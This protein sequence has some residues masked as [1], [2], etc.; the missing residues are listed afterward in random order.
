MWRHGGFAYVANESSSK[1]DV[2]SHLS[3]LS[4]ST[5]GGW[6]LWLLSGTARLARQL[7]R[8]L[9]THQRCLE[10]VVSQRVGEQ[11][12]HG[13]WSSCARA[14]L[15]LVLLQQLGRLLAQCRQSQ[16]LPG[17]LLLLSTALRRGWL[18]LAHGGSGCECCWF[19]LNVQ[20][21]RL[22]AASR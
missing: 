13:C 18:R 3:T 1:P 5:S 16:S 7:R 17:L 4:K 20:R 11:H 6:Q 14:A 9:S 22:L 21:E 12:G 8:T 2:L 10:W 15:E 19:S